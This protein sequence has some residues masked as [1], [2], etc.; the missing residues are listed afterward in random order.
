[1]RVERVVPRL[2]AVVHVA[3]VRAEKPGAGREQQQ[4]DGGERHAAGPHVQHGEEAAE[5]HQRRADVADHEQQHHRAAPDDQQRAEV[6]QRRDR[7]PHEP[8]RAEHEHLPRVA[9][10][11][12]EEDDD[13]DLRELRRL[14]GERPEV[15]A[16]VGAVDLAADPGQPGQ[17]QHPDAGQRD[18]VAVALEDRDVA[19][20][21]DRRGEQEEARDEPLRLLAGQRLVDPV[22]DDQAE[23]RQRGNQREQVRV[24]VRERHAHDDMARNAE[25]EERRAVG[26]RDVGQRVRALDEDRREAGRDQQRRRD[27]REQLA[28][29]LAHRVLTRPSSSWRTRLMASS[30]ER[31]EWSSS[32]RLRAG[33]IVAATTPET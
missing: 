24:R 30:C 18:H 32:L 19:Q 33:G 20:Q 2:D 8:P 31:R 1:V 10:V 29:A 15:R 13:R 6:L 25:R 11:A 22:D 5:E 17:D 16:E 9:Q 23:A 7:Q 27:Q 28:V 3:D 14:E 26:Q 4:P 12:R 21:D